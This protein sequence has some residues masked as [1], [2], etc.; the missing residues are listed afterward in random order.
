MKTLFLIFAA[1]IL[2]TA[3]YSQSYMGK[4]KQEIKAIADET[5]DEVE[6]ISE[7]PNSLKLKCDTEINEFLLTDNICVKFNS[8]KSYKCDCLATDLKAYNEN[9]KA[10]G[11]MKWASHDGS[12]LYE[13]RLDKEDY[14]VSI[15]TTDMNVATLK[16]N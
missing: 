10:I 11:N 4:S 6:V 1:L 13:I 9:L 14:V 3:A 12:R 8:T 2:S 7:T 16:T 15:S 5:Y